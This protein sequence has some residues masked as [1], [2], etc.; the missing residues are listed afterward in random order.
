MAEQICVYGHIGVTLSPKIAASLERMS[1]YG[2]KDPVL[3]ELSVTGAW[4]LIL[5]GKYSFFKSIMAE[6]KCA[7]GLVWGDPVRTNC[8]V[9]KADGHFAV[10][11]T[12]Y[13]Q[14]HHLRVPGSKGY[15]VHI[16]SLH[17]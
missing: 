17:P 1:L 11:R 3:P 9:L 10:A 12:L 4:V 14:Y 2:S 6:Q 16:A 7:C 15:L 13:Y 8:R 5:F